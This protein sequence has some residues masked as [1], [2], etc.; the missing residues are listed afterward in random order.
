MTLAQEVSNAALSLYLSGKTLEE[1]EIILE[2]AYIE[3]ARRDCGGNLLHAS[4]KLHWHRNTLSRRVNDLGIDPSVFYPENKK[5]PHYRPAQ[6][7][8]AFARRSA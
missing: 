1:A 2:R 6:R 5:G 3:E 7:V 4:E 8:L